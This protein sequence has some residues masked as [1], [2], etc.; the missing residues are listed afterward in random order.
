MV[1]IEVPIPSR[2]HATT[3][4]KCFSNAFK[5]EKLNTKHGMTGALIKDNLSLYC[6]ILDDM[7]NAADDET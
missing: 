3:A 2:P 4:R 5:E 7:Y 6:H 1:V